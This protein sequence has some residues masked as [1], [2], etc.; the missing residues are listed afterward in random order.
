MQAKVQIEG[1]WFSL[2]TYCICRHILLSYVVSVC[3]QQF[4]LHAIY[5]MQLSYSSKFRVVVSGER[6]WAYRSRGKF[7]NYNNI[8]QVFPT[9]IFITHGPC[10]LTFRLFVQRLSSRK[11]KKN[12]WLFAENLHIWAP[13]IK[14][15][16][17]LL[18]L[19]Y[20]IFCYILWRLRYQNTNFF[21]SHCTHTDYIVCKT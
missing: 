10:T 14:V 7:V 20:L 6:W 11:A 3:R 16:K 1:T 21:M 2:W 17:A 13:Y 5:G 15:G 4:L 8:N 12:V 9:S 18:I 19:I